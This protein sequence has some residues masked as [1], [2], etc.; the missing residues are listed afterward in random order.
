MRGASRSHSSL[1]R[2]LICA[3]AIVY[4]IKLL[5]VTIEVYHYCIITKK[6][7]QII[8]LE[9]PGMRILSPLLASSSS[10]FGIN[11]LHHDWAIE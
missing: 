8:S 3:Q 9:T 6:W 2:D 7:L 1:Y 10:R 11:N 4:Y 5:P